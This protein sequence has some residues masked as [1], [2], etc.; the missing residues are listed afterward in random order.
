MK[1]VKNV[2]IICGHV[3][4]ENTEHP[5]DDDYVCPECGAESIMFEEQEIEV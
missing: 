2:C 3:H 1:V 5:L 4:D